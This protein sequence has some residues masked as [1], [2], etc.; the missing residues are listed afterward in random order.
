MK[1]FKNKEVQLSDDS[2]SDDDDDDK[3]LPNSNKIIPNSLRNQS[4]NSP[5]AVRKRRSFVDP[6]MS[7]SDWFF[8]SIFYYSTMIL[9]NLIITKSFDLFSYAYLLNKYLQQKFR[10]KLLDYKII[11][12]IKFNDW[13]KINED[14]TLT[15]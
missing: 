8:L 6:S 9:T 1:K 3:R 7:D 10:V 2:C 13:L 5:V 4:S 15:K 12:L 11:P 14:I